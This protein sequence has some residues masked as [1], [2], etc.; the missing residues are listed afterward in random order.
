MVEVM[1]NSSNRA[2]ILLVINTSF[3]IYVRCGLS[4]VR[5][6]SKNAM[7]RLSF[8]QRISHNRTFAAMV[9]SAKR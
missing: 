3:Q 7:N 5:C 2:R 4:V 8:N 1:C 6:Q 9:I